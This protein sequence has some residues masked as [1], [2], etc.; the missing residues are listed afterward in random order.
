MD[1]SPHGSS[2][3]GIFQARILEWVTISGDLPD[4]GIKLRS[5]ALQAKSL[6]SEPPG[7]PNGILLRH[8]N[9]EILPFV[10]TWIDS[11][12]IY[13]N[14]ISQTEKDKYCMISFIC[15]T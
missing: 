1:Y 14:E 12:G 4:P 13:A 2:V 10:A 9:N 8:K 6:P 11:E 7:N 3:H 15:G 5:P